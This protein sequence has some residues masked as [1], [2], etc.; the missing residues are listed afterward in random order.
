[1]DGLDRRDAE[2]YA[3]AAQGHVRR[4][5]RLATDPEARAR[6]HDGLQS[7]TRLPRP[8]PGFPAARRPIR[9][10]PAQA[11]GPHTGPPAPP[12]PAAATRLL[13]KRQKTRDTRA[14]RDSL[15]RALVDL[16]AFYRDALA[17][18]FGAR[19]P[20]IHPDMAETTR[21]AAGRL[22]AE[23]LLRRIDAI[24]ECRKAI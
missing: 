8:A 3:A 21:A 18:G 10:A 22:S 20:P 19:V 13:E 16:A 6:R 12:P 1:R 11:A 7:P 17:A 14:Q 24:L 4:A 2:L 15:D 9:D 5:R 23:S